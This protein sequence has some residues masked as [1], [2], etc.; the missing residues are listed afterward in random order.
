MHNVRAGVLDDDVAVAVCSVEAV[1]IMV[2]LT[3]TGLVCHGN[4]MWPTVTT[5]VEEKAATCVLIV[6]PMG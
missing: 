1:L 2:F 6:V 5:E 3:G 4:K